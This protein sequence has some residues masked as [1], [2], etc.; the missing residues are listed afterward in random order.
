MTGSLTPRSVGSL[1]AVAAS[2]CLTAGCG[3][4]G[5]RKAVKGDTMAAP[6]RDTTAARHPDVIYVPTPRHIVERMIALAD[7]DSNDVLFDL[8]SGDGRIVVEAAKRGAR[9]IGIDIDP[10]R[11]AE[12]KRN[13]QE[14]G[15]TSRAEF[16]QD[17]LF[18]TDLRSAT[19]VTLYLLPTLNVKLRPKLFDELRPGTPVVSHNFPMS[20][21]IPD[22]T[23]NLRGSSVFLWYI[24]ANVSGVWTLEIGGEGGA[25]TETAT[26][27]LRL[28]QQF[29]QVSGTLTSGG[30]SHPLSRTRLR[31]PA[32]SFVVRDSS[33][34]GVT[35]QYQG[36]I[37]GPAFTG[38]VARG[39]GRATPF[40]GS[41]LS[42]AGGIR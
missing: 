14:A 9:A 13:A 33:R 12:G 41:R 42:P 34:G 15:V 4:G 1:L 21:W 35:R 40:R 17:D 8:G 23:L 2:L 31:G 32:L 6:S 38:T 22:S 39:R 10:V 5:E 28:D 18:A 37:D 36:E 26:D 19:A 24:P 30:R 3:A 27:T 20:D 29:Q 11:V 16:R 7:V 25:A